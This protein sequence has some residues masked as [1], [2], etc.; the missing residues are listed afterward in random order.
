MKRFI[1]FILF[2]VLLFG[3]LP[4]FAS[5]D[6][7]KQVTIVNCDTGRPIVTANGTSTFTMETKGN[8]SIH[9]QKMARTIMWISA[10]PPHKASSRP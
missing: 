1:S 6:S 10:N 3:A 2:F 4:I 5:N 8:I 9:A 7:V